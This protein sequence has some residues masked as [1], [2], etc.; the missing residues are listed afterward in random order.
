MHMFTLT[1]RGKL[2]GLSTLRKAKTSMS[3]AWRGTNSP[4]FLD[5]G[6]GREELPSLLADRGSS[7]ARLPLSVV[8]RASIISGPR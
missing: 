6:V 7:V 3:S 2:T 5:E 1:S 8:V 4:S